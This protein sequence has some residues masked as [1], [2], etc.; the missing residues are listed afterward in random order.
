M[1]QSTA[2]TAMVDNQIRPADVTRYDIL[3][4]FLEV[5]R[6]NYL[7]VHLS[8]LAYSE[9]ELDLTAERRVMRP[10]SLAK[11]IAAAHPRTA[12]VA[13][14]VGGN[15][16]YEAAILARLV[17]SI[18]IV[19]AD[20]TLADRAEEN[21][22]EDGVDNAVV[23]KGALEEGAV[24]SAPYDLI[25]LNGAVQAVPEAL[26]DQLS[27]DMGRLITI[28]EENGV[29]TG[30]VFVKNGGDVDAHKLFNSA[31]PLLPG[32]RAKEKFAF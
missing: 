8:G 16:G 4:A 29:F 12:D 26:F 11:L 20:K 19:E 7:P 2:R 24:K 13:L 28:V 1:N 17:D 21:L 30:T 23:L 22:R 32:F 27:P 31:A 9:A 25:V 5:R 6:E 15:H 3:A 18:I 10:R 14:L